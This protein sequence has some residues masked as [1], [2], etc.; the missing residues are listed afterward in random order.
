MEYMIMRYLIIFTYKR[1]LP[2]IDDFFANFFGLAN[3]SV[4]GFMAMVNCYSEEGY[5]LLNRGT[6]LPPKMTSYQ[7]FQPR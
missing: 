1:M 5:I 4:A 6:G 3:V 7:K 2:I